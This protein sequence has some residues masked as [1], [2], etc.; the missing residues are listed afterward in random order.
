MIRI[1]FKQ[2]LEDKKFDDDKKYSLSYIAETT[3]I[4]RA[5]IGRI[6][7]D[8]KHITTTDVIDKLCEFFNCQPGELLSY[9]PNKDQNL[10][11]DDGAKM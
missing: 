4:S 5:T 1:K 8:P 10:N 6:S 7:K 2:L 9:I 3:G 11:S